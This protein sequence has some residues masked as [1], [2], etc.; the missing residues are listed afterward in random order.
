MKYFTLFLSKKII[1]SCLILL[2]SISY[3]SAQIVNEG[4]LKI[5]DGTTVYFGE[6]YTNKVGATHNNEG[7][8]HLNSNFINNGIMTES[9]DSDLA[10]GTTYFDSPT[11]AIQTISGTTKVVFENLDVDN[12]TGVSVADGMELIVEK[13]VT[14]TSGDLRM[15][16]ESQL[17]QKHTGTNAN[18]G[19]QKLLLDQQGKNIVFDYNYWASPVSG[20]TIGQYEV[21]EILFDGSDS[22]I[23]PYTPTMVNYTTGAPW[24][25]TP[26]VIDGSGNVTTALNI[27]SYWIWKFDNGDVDQYNDWILL[28][29][30][31]AINVGLGYTMK[32]TGTAS[33]TQNYVFKGKPNDGNYTIA[34]STNKSSLLGNPYPSAL[35]A[36]TFINA[37][38]N[39]LADVTTPS[40]T[41]GVLYFWEH[42]GGGTHFRYDYQG[43]YATYS[44]AGGVAATSLYGNG[45]TSTGYVPPANYKIP[46]A[47][48]FFIEAGTGGPHTVV[49]NNS[50]RQF[51]VEGANSNFFRPSVETEN[52]TTTTNTDTTPRIRLGYESP[53]N[54][55][56]QIMTAFIPACNDGHN[57]AY[58]AKMADVNTEDM[59]WVTNTIPYVIDAR[60]FNLDQQ[61]PIGITVVNN[62]THTISIDYIENFDNDIYILDTNT[63]FTHDLRQSNFEVI[64]D[65]GI[66][67]SRFKLVFRPANIVGTDDLTMSDINVFFAPDSENVIIDNFDKLTLK[68][69]KIYNALGQLIKNISDNKLEQNKI[70]VPF[71]VVAGTYFINVKTANSTGDFK[72]IAY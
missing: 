32:G 51:Q 26:S 7:D 4:T 46:V 42:W 20:T 48:G 67:D 49:F 53:V 41:T 15:I 17:I 27:E 71:N 10:D 57:M 36:D 70:T 29:N 55:Y 33:A 59:Y 5:E 60:S 69:V 56:R 6:E 8:L 21:G 31:T 37:N 58:D 23:N 16:G 14:L 1:I 47:Q 34:I 38:A 2:F 22:S 40:A 13:A 3:L 11:N 35:D 44:L 30:N 68:S 19:T 45:G 72:I 39:V 43:G 24:N 12:T 9:A 52:E 66:Y 25:G 50:M 54:F 65:S 64:L 62:G 63:G 61:I 28:R 18:T